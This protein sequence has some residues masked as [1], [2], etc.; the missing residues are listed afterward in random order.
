MF[1]KQLFLRI[2]QVLF[3]GI[4]FSNYVDGN[5][6]IRNLLVKSIDVT[7]T[8]SFKTELETVQQG[9]ATKSY[10]IR[11]FDKDGNL[12]L[13]ND[14]YVNGT[15][16]FSYL[17][18]DGKIYQITKDQVVENNVND[19]AANPMLAWNF[20]KQIKMMLKR[21]DCQYDI[22]YT[23]SYNGVSC[24]GVTVNVPRDKNSVEK[25]FPG[26]D[27]KGFPQII[28]FLIGK[29]NHFIYQ[30]KF[31][32][33]SGSEQGN[34]EFGK[35]TLNPKY[36][37]KIFEL[38]AEKELKVARK[39]KDIEKIY[40]PQPSGFSRMSDAVGKFFGRIGSG[41]DSNFNFLTTFFSWA[42]LFV[43]VGCVGFV[44]ALKLKNRR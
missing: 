18:R 26:S 35:V 8:A 41:I 22:S 5:D 4:V 11:I 23:K 20:L 3:I 33:E 36:D 37:P 15:L 12:F 21:M 42:F 25:A 31:Y 2:F 29:S 39:A 10:L 9:K 7:D 16:F 14:I 6:E 19:P 44:I 17:M 30:T 1:L 40:N 34:V 32:D 24:N 13:R 38:P 28:V 43:A 27:P